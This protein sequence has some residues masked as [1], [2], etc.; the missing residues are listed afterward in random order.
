VRASRITY[1]GELGW[2]IYIP[3]EFAPSVFDALMKE[4]EP[5]GL[6]LAGYHALNS[7]RMEKG[8]RHW[9]HDI[10]DEDTPLQSGLGFAV[11]WNKPSGFLGKDALLAQ[12]AEGTTRTLVQFALD[13]PDA[14]LYHNEP[15]CR[16]GVIV[17]RISSGM[18]GHTL[19]KSLGMGYVEHNTK[20]ASML[21]GVYEIEVA[22]VRLKAQPSL[23]PFYDPQSLRIKETVK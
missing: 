13:T 9:G 1:V 19:G 14:L 15:I 8:Y 10:S 18:F 6:R 5:L 23:I 17:G 2:E 16:D 22:G 21:E 4:G 20:Y 7:L 12:K 11:A 3:V